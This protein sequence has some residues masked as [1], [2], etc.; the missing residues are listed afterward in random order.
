MSLSTL[1]REKSDWVREQTLLLH[2]LAPET[3]VASSLSDVEI[4]TVLFY[5]QVMEHF[6]KDPLSDLR[7]RFIVSKGHGG[8]SLYPILAD[9]GFFPTSELAKICSEGTFLGGIPDPIIPGFETVNG[10]LGHGLGVA[11]GTALALRLQNKSHF[12]FVVCGDGELYEG[13]IWEAAMFAPH[14]Q[15]D[16]LMV[17]VDFNQTAMLNFTEKIINQNSLANKFTAFGWEVLEIDGHDVDALQT[18]ISKAKANRNGKP[19]VILA[20]T[21]KGK[22]AP[23]LEGNPLSHITSVKKEE[24]DRILGAKS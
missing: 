6:P 17:L 15:L 10:S 14:H 16:N 19:K 2:R 12:T 22:G 1:L 3:R 8:L 20:R 21:V 7:D 11:C 18:T 4:F 13:S 23:T 24:I 5:G 9:R